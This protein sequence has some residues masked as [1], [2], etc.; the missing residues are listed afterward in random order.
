MVMEVLVGEVGLR[1][2]EG[3]ASGFTVISHA[4]KSLVKLSPCRVHVA[5]IPPTDKV[6]F[7]ATTYRQ[8]FARQPSRPPASGKISRFPV[9]ASS[10]RSAVASSSKSSP[11]GNRW[12]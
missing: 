8:L 4:L 11:R 10:D 7:L 12:P 3:L 2:Y 9:H 5:S 6:Y 1:T